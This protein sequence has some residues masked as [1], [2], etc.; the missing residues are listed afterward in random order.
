MGEHEDRR[1]D[2][3]HARANHVGADTRQG[4]SKRL[5]NLTRGMTFGA[6]NDGRTLDDQER[7][8]VIEQMKREG[9]LR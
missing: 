3:A 8:K 1:F 4:R 7:R 9:V 2:N 6:A 5:N